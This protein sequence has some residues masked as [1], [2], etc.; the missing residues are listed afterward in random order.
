MSRKYSN[1]DRYTD[2]DSG[3]LYNKFGIQDAKEL[4]RVEADYVAARTSQL[5]QTP[6]SGEFGFHYLR[7]IHRH[8]FQD[9][10]E[11]AGEIRDIDIQKGSSYFAHYNH[12]EAAGNALFAKLREEKLLA[13]LDED[14]FSA[15]AAFYLGEINA[16]HPFREGNGRTQREFI[17]QLAVNN[18]Y[19]I[20]W[21]GITQQEMIDASAASFNGNTTPLTALIRSRI[22]RDE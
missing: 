20:D 8:L 4:N 16:L 1:A 17:S 15:R 7:A 2:P 13:G 3:V 21:T 5:T 10:Y 22:T 18:G 14:S 6:H 12:I 19:F 9:V 11:W